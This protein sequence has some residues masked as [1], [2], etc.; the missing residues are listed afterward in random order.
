MS[1]I[2]YGPIVGQLVLTDVDQG[3]PWASLGI[4]VTAHARAHYRHRTQLGAERIAGDG[5]AH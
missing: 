1:R 3:Q 2:I 5:S 4:Y